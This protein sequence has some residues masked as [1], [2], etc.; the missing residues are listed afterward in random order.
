MVKMYDHFH[1]EDDG[2]DGVM[3]RN[4]NEKSSARV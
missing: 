1:H 4:V 3:T 2:D